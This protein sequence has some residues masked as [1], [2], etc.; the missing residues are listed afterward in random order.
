MH[1]FHY[2]GGE[3][4]CE[5][6][7]LREVA[8]QVGTPCYV[9]SAATLTRHFLV[10]DGG[11]QALPH[12]TCFAVKSCSNLAILNL[13]ARLGGGADIVSGG[14]LFRAL[15]SGIPA[16]RIIYSGVG[17]SVREL[18]EALRAGILM[19]NIES[20]QEL[21]RVRQVAASVGVRA[22]VAFRVNPD[23]DPKTHAY[24]ST[25]LAKNKFGVPVDEALAEYV[26]AAAMPEIEVVGL[27]C[28]IGSQLTQ[29][30]PFIEALRKLKDFLARLAAAGVRVRC[31]DLGG[32]LGI[33]YDA[34]TPPH[35]HDY[36]AAI[37]RE[38]AGL[39]LT[40][41][42]EPGRVLVGNAG[43]LLTEVQFIKQNLGA[44]ERK[45][46]VVVDAAMNDL[47]R[48]SL[49]GAYHEI[50]RVREPAGEDELQVD[51]V[52]PICESGDFLA[53][54]R[55]LPPLA[56]G[57]L[58]AVMSSGA[59]GFSMASNYNSRPRAA[60][61]LVSGSS[62]QVIRARESYEDL[63]RGETAAAGGDLA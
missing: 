45:N 44:G 12:Q 9:Y 43:I 36:A 20:P 40:L 26:R 18:E 38:L 1:H 56:A 48:P 41:I 24:I 60:E 63:V 42:L 58:L 37:T 47:A 35:P 34:E 6:V 17:K 5:E 30:E 28:H 49:Y 27:S 16:E 29:V 32:G 57:D 61:V 11:F 31:L 53:K 15:R 62:I 14:E 54:D 2:R 21:D 46:F 19:I 25:G 3:L 55:M 51:V 10:F 39:D 4:C 13:F 22:P 8:R 50:R 59:Y 33:T 23:V 52:G 7:P